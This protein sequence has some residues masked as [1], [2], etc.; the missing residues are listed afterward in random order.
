MDGQL[1]IDPQQI[2]QLFGERDFE[3]LLLR[4]QIAQL[5]QEI[6]QLREESDA[7]DKT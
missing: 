1:T 7:T 4:S 3:I 2:Q 6:A 5:Q